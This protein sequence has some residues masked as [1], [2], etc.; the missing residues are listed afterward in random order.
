MVVKRELWVLYT[1]DLLAERFN[2]R[3]RSG[4]SSIGVIGGFKTAV[5]EHDGAH[6]LD[7]VI[8]ISKVVHR[9][10]LLVDDSNTS[11]VCAASDFLNVGG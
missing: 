10:E 4:F 9:L 8:T 3:R 6:V 2:K 1:L 7:T 11:F 5:D